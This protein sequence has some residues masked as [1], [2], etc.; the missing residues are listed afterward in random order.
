MLHRKLETY[1]INFFITFTTKTKCTICDG[2]GILQN[3]SPDELTFEKSSSSV[4]SRSCPHCNSG[5]MDCREC[6]GKGR[7]ACNICKGE[8][9]VVVA[10]RL[11]VKW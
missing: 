8:G 11:A 7:I 3:F 10:I 9:A 6:R 5:R 1:K 2:L 4:A